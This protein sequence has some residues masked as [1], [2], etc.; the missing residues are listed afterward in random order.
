MKDL[1]TLKEK[2]EIQEEDLIHFI[3]Q[4]IKYATLKTK[5]DRKKICKKIEEI[6]T[7]KNEEILNK[8]EK[9][10]EDQDGQA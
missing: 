2:L 7:K 9:A 8:V 5:A 4:Y 10:L 6:I 3:Y 1:A